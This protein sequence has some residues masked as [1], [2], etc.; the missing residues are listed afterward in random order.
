MIETPVR[1]AKRTKSH[2]HQ[3]PPPGASKPVEPVSAEDSAAS[4]KQRDLFDAA[5]DLFTST[6]L[7]LILILAIALACLAGALIAQAPGEMV[8]TPE[9]MRAYAERMRPRYG[10]FTDLFQAIGLF[11]VFQTVWFRALFGLLAINTVICT[12]DRLPKIWKQVFSKPVWPREELF[13]RGEPRQTVLLPGLTAEAATKLVRRA[14]TGYRVVEHPE[15]S[16]ALLYADRFR[17]ARFGTI[18]THTAIVLVLAVAAVGGSLGY[19]E[20]SGFT[21]PVGTTREVGHDTG[22]VVL[23]EDFAD[24]YYVNGEP[25]DYRSEL[26]LFSQGTEVARQ[27]VRVNEPLIYNGVRFHQSFYGQAVM[28]TVRDAAGSVLTQEPVPLAYRANDSQRPMGILYLPTRDLNLYLVGTVGQGD[29]MIRSGEVAVEVYRGRVNLPT[30]RA[31]LTQNQPQT[32]GDLQLTF[33][34]EL[35]FTGLRIVKVPGSQLIWIASTMLVGG[36]LLAFYFPHRRLWT[37]LRLEPTG[38]GVALAGAGKD[39]A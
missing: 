8:K 15:S 20:E 19:F 7:A 9:A 39:M 35:P 21:V 33:E 31:M 29:K 13:E 1:P 26:V 18:L 25:K 14:L 22:L 16:S 34:R 17:L 32:V 12:V 24:E 3:K 28:L 36:I 11:T 2:A 27:T 30:A 37:R 5:W 38:V 23:A 4:A 10:M 6:K